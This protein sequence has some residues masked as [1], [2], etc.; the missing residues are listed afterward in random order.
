MT[1]GEATGRAGYFL[2]RLFDV[3][4]ELLY[5]GI[6]LN[7]AKRVQQHRK[8]QPWRNKIAE[9]KIESFA[10]L[11][12]ASLAEIKAIEEEAPRFNKQHF[13]GTSSAPVDLVSISAQLQRM[14]LK[15]QAGDRYPPAADATGLLSEKAAAALLSMSVRSLQ[16]WRVKGGGPRF[17]KIGKSVR[18]RR[19]DIDAFI[20][21]TV[22]GST[23]E[24]AAARSSLLK[25]THL[26][27]FASPMG[28]V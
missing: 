27:D 3:A 9:I 8:V 7:P 18:Y 21:A 28:I 26:P 17:C 2:Y 24:V 6:S 23:A 14:G 22:V 12:L 20:E 11:G 4:G 1:E 25:P 19:Q 15:V 13:G 10:H 5:V 16:G